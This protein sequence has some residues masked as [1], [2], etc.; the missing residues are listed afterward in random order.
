MKGKNVFAVFALAVVAMLGVGFV[1]ANGFGFGRGDLTEEERAQMD[2][3]REVMRNAVE[4]GDYA[5]WEG[6][7]QERLAEFEDSINEET[8]AEIQVRHEERAEIREAM[9]EA[10][11][12]GD[13]SEV[14]ALRDEF[15]PEAKAFGRKHLGRDF[16]KRHG[17]SA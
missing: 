16:A 10:R 17:I 13:W 15:S 9:Q 12:S 5:A 8:F 2:A 1:S 14:E 7:M 4:S 6:L 3:N 11:E